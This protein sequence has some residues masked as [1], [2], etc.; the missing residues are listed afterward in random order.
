[1]NPEKTSEVQRSLIAI[2]LSLEDINITMDL[3]LLQL[4]GCELS[5]FLKIKT[6]YSISLSI[7]LLNW[8]NALHF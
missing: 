1:M 8:K 2:T 5:K 7:F 6:E 3:L 4:T